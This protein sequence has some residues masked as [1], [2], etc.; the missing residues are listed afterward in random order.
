MPTRRTLLAAGPLLA[1]PRVLHAAPR[2]PLIGRVALDGGRLFTSAR[3]NNEQFLFII[4]SGTAQN[5]I[6]PEVAARLKL[7]AVGNRGLQG[8]GRKTSLVDL[9]V[10]HDVIVGGIARQSQ[11]LFQSY[12]F[13]TGMRR[14]IAGLFA[15]G[16]LTSYATALD[17]VKGEWS[18][19]LDGL[20]P[21]EGYRPWPARITKMDGE[22]SARIYVDVK[23]DGAPLR[24]MLDTGSPGNVLLFPQTSARLKLFDAGRTFTEARTLGFGGEAR[25]PSRQMR[26]GGL[27]VGAFRFEDLAYTAMDP[28]EPRKGFGADGVLGLHLLGLFDVAIDPR[29]DRLLV[30]RNALPYTEHDTPVRR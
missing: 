7:T 13:G 18:L 14:D 9:H 21:L 24:L 23:F 5:L 10:A 27:Q 20:P 11:M 17:F 8:L 16:V 29:G 12:Q 3:I 1:L 28:R 25:F 2:P 26:A 6:R 15:A 4:D 30:R 19:Y 22:D